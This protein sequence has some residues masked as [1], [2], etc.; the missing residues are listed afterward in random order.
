MAA[1]AFQRPPIHL[2]LGIILLGGETP[3][4]ATSGYLQGLD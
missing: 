2:A 1:K 3:A 4:A